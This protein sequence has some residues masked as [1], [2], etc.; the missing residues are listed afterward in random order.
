LGSD[1]KERKMGQN[2]EVRKLIELKNKSKERRKIKIIVRSK[3]DSEQCE[4]RF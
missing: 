1:L 3:L 2:L 4:A